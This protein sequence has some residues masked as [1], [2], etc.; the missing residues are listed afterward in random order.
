MIHACPS[1]HAFEFSDI[2]LLGTRVL[3]AESGLCLKL[4]VYI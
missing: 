3:V 1:A 4:E 2:V